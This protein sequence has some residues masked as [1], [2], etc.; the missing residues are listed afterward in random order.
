MNK[1][2]LAAVA[3]IGFGAPAFAADVPTSAEL[4]AEAPV[5]DWSGF[6]VGVSGGY[7]WTDVDPSVTHS[8]PTYTMGAAT[9]FEADDAL[10]GAQIGYN[11][12]LN[13]W[14]FGVEADF[15][16]TFYDDPE[17]VPFSYPTAAGGNFGIP[18]HSEGYVESSVEWLATVRARAGLNAGRFLP[19]VTAG[20]AFGKVASAGGYDTDTSGFEGFEN[21]GVE[22]GWTAGIGAEYA[23]TDRLSLKLEYLHVDLG[24]A[25]GFTFTDATHGDVTVNP[26][27][28]MNIV[29]A[30]LNLR[31]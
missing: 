20:V 5:Y 17:L 24:E 27:V 16:W 18:G 4:Y 30:G 25:D 19:Y 15:A 26:D 21:D 10:I 3:A 9:D 1:L 22:V 6:Y 11:S 7:S 8:S 23:V 13:S 31:F 14:V 28:S 2:A 29:K 12:A